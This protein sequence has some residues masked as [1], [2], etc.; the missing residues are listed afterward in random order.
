MMWRSLIVPGSLS[1]ALQTMYLSGPGWLR[2]SSHFMPVGKPAPPRPRRPLALSVAISPVQSFDCANDR[3][4]PYCDAWSGY[5]SHATR[6]SAEG[7]LARGEL[8]RRR[9]R[10]REIDQRDGVGLADLSKI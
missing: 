10:E 1:S 3:S 7:R 2:T 6:E 4:T 9:A 8:R 5:G